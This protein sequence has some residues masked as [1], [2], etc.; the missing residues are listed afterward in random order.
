MNTDY[1]QDHILQEKS[2]NTII[3]TAGNLHTIA[4]GAEEIRFDGNP[5]SMT[6][7]DTLIEL[8][9]SG[10]GTGT[11]TIAPEA[12]WLA[13]AGSDPTA[14]DAGLILAH[15]LA[16][17]S[18]M[19]TMALQLTLL[20]GVVEDVERV[21]APCGV[22]PLPPYR[23]DHFTQEVLER[24]DGSREQAEA[25]ARLL[26]QDIETIFCWAAQIGKGV[27]PVV[28][29]Q[30]ASNG[31]VQAPQESEALALTIVE[32]VETGVPLQ[33]AK[34]PLFR[35]T[36]EMVE[37]LTTEFLSATEPNNS[38]V[39]KAIAE[40]HGWPVERVE[41]K[42]YH[43][44]LPQRRSAQRQREHQDGADAQEGDQRVPHASHDQH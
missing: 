21:V 2:M 42:I 5:C 27:D 31:H 7:N 6:V 12:L 17:W 19:Q 14:H 28:I 43:L 24:F 30:H 32:P 13:F 1:Q 40:R 25:I 38:A 4:A 20:R 18:A 44:D 23:F 10:P 16:R 8:T 33:Q 26:K 35:W 41:Y 29:N 36:S 34:R 15:A 3:D 9:S 11:I 39:A 37:E 22:P